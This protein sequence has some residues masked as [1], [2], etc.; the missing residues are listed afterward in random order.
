MKRSVVWMASVFVFGCVVS[1]DAWGSEPAWNDRHCRIL[2]RVD[3]R[4]IGD[5]ASDEIPA[6]VEIDFAELLKRKGISALP[7]I[8]TIRVEKYDPG[9]GKAE[10]YGQYAYAVGPADRPFRWYDSAIPYDF[11]EFESNIDQTNG[12]ISWNPHP[13][14]GH[15]YNVIGDWQC[16]RLCWIHTQN[17]ND[18]SFYAISF[19]LL[20]KGRTPDTVP[21]R[22]FMGDGTNR[23]DKTGG[24]MTSQIHVRVAVDDWNDDGPLDL[25]V[26][27]ARGGVIWFPNTRTKSKPSFPYSKLLF[28]ADGKPLDIGWSATPYVVDWDGDGIKDLL[29][30]AEWN[31]IVFI[32][33][34]GDNRNRKMV[35]KGMLKADGETLAL[36][37]EPVPEIPGVYKRDY[38]PVL[39]V[40][41]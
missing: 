39:E 20:P 16:G 17:G 5:R 41:D 23:C 7:D 38:Y 24:R 10:T 19:D 36:P 26:G 18:P 14:W 9:T 40:A 22:G 4:E 31:R 1:T 27:G 32:Q 6:D 2:V 28:Y 29:V 35:Y 8:T 33:N 30:G 15:F 13:R 34:Q 12:V 37:W 25:V 3:A 11:P 21:P